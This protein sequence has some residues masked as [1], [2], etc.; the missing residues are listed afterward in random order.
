MVIRKPARWVAIS[1]VGAAWLADLRSAWRRR[2][3][4]RPLR[5]ST[6]RGRPFYQHVTPTELLP[7]YMH[8]ALPQHHNVRLKLRTWIWSRTVCTV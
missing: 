3:T 8:G 5:A 2:G 7:E 4:C 6:F 1:P